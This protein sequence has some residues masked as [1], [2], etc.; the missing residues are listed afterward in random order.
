MKKNDKTYPIKISIL[1]RIYCKCSG[2]GNMIPPGLPFT[3]CAECNKIFCATC[4]L[5]ETFEKHD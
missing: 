2:C 4:I 5:N 3:V 1:K